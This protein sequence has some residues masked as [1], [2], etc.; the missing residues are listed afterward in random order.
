MLLGGSLLDEK[1]VK[2][3]LLANAEACFATE[4]PLELREWFAGEEART[5]LRV[6]REFIAYM[7]TMDL[8]DLLDKINVSTLILASHN[9]PIIHLE[10]Q[11]MMAD[12]IPQAEMKVF[13]GVGYNVKVEIPDLLAAAVVTFVQQVDSAG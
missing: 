7:V 2:R 12:R 8:G 1:G 13:G 6:A 11:E 10:V 9:D 5:P 4:I 3:R